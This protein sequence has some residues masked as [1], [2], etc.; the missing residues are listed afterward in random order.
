MNSGAISGTSL[1]EP[2][3][4]TGYVNGTGTLANV[5]FTGTFSPGLGTASVNLGSAEYDG[6][7]E[8]EIGGLSPGTE[9]DQIN[10]NIGSGV[11]QLGGTLNV[12]L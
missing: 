7:L 4:L 8:I 10:H 5:A 3:T 9:Y 6:T 1:A 2:L 12:S 11:A